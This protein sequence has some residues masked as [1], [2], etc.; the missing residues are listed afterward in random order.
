MKAKKYNPTKWIEMK[1]PIEGSRSAYQLKSWNPPK[2]NWAPFT[3]T[4]SNS[5]RK[6]KQSNKPKA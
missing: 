6:R 3:E 4:D 5:G 1:K 2:T